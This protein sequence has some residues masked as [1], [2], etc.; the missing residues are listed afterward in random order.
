M[1]T[2]KPAEARERDAIHAQTIEAIAQFVDEHR[3]T[4]TTH[5]NLL[6]NPPQNGCAVFLAR[7]IRNLKDPK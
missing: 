3:W 5:E 4:L 2:D 6:T 7:K 1:T